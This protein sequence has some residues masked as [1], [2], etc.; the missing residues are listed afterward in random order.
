LFVNVDQDGDLVLNK[1]EVLLIAIRQFNLS[2]SDR[3]GMLEK[4]EVGDLASD[5][6]FSDN[7]ANKDGALSLE[8][9]ISEKLADFKAADTNSD[10]VL[11]VIEVTKFYENK[12]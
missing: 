3:D 9:V 2:D 1:G 6:E 8:E 10:G 11:T 12:K 5:P 7:D 4:Q